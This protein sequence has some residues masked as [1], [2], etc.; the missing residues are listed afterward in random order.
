MIECSAFGAQSS[1]SIAD[2]MDMPMTKDLIEYG[3]EPF[4]KTF[5]TALFRLVP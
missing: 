1:Y 4:A 2:L 5:D 3:Y